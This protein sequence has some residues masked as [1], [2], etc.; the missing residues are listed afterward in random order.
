MIQKDMLEKTLRFA[1]SLLTGKYC[2]SY[3]LV[4]IMRYAAA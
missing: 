4:L 1:L 3:S 2:P